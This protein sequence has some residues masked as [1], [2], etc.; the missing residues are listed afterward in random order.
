MSEFVTVEVDTRDAYSISLDLAIADTRM[1]VAE[2]YG[3]ALRDCDGNCL[4]CGA[5]E[6]EPDETCPNC[7][8]TTPKRFVC[9]ECGSPHVLQ[10]AYIAVND[11]SDIRSFNAFMCD[12]CG[13][14]KIT[15]K[16]L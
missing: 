4:R 3:V 6:N 16:E 1:Q 2:M 5:P 13:V 11:P 15:P 12:A 9:P 7:E 8:R 14:S 10:D